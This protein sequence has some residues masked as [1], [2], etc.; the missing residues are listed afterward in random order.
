LVF[1]GKRLPAPSHGRQ[2][3]YVTGGVEKTGGIQRFKL[4]LHG[5][6][7][8]TAA[9][10]AYVQGGSLEDWQLQI[11]NWIAELAANSSD[12]EEKWLIEEQL[13]AFVKNDALHISSASSVHERRVTAISAEINLRHLWVLMQN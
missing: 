2:R 11:N 9:I 3:E 6:K 8:R 5:A 12:G 4:A 10:V 7:Q 13:I 1:E